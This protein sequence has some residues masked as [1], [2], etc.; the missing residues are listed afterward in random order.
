MNEE[1]FTDRTETT[2]GSSKEAFKDL[3]DAAKKAFDAG[4]RDASQAAKNAVPNFKEGVRDSVYDVTYTLAYGAV[5]AAT[6]IRN[7]VPEAMTTG[8][9][10]GAD[11]GR[12]A[13]DIFAAKQKEK[14][15]KEG[16]E[17]AAG[18]TTLQIEGA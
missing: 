13:A 11:S 14:R 15:E 12:K 10:E 9:A 16:K 2:P 1:P 4:K 7:I 3:A 5:F 18:D 8:F 17:E 6:L